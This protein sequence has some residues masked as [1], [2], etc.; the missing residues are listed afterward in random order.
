MTDS[1]L[2]A[3]VKGYAMLAPAEQA[4]VRKALVDLVEAQKALLAAKRRLIETLDTVLPQG[5]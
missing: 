1:D 2:T 5:R 3:L 4:M